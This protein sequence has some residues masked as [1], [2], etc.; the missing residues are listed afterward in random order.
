M[1]I[2]KSTG[3]YYYKISKNGKKTRISEKAYYKILSKKN[4]KY[5]FKGGGGRYCNFSD[6]RQ[7]DVSI[8]V[9]TPNQQGTTA[10]PMAAV[11]N[12]IDI[13]LGNN[14]MTCTRMPIGERNLTL[15]GKGTYGDIFSPGIV[16]HNTDIYSSDSLVTK[17][18]IEKRTNGNTRT[19]NNT[20]GQNK[21]ADRLG[22]DVTFCTYFFKSIEYELNRE[23]LLTI[24]F[25]DRP[26]KQHRIRTAT[27]TNHHYNGAKVITME[28]GDSINTIINTTNLDNRTR[29]RE[30]FTHLFRGCELLAHNRIML[31]D[32]KPDNM[33]L[34]R[35][36]P[37]Q[38]TIIKHIDL[39][40]DFLVT[41]L[42][43]YV[44]F[45]ENFEHINNYYFNNFPLNDCIRQAYRDYHTTAYRTRRLSIG[46]INFC[47][48]HPERE[49]VRTMLIPAGSFDDFLR[50]MV[51]KDRNGEQ[52]DA[53]ENRFFVNLLTLSYIG[54][55]SR[56]FMS[57]PGRG[58][59]NQY[60]SGYVGFLNFQ[61]LIAR[62][63]LDY[64]N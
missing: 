56:L 20:V 4:Y 3:G 39:G 33:L 40:L 48:T 46:I 10:Q 42:T 16:L 21:I 6:P 63:T 22:N 64:S 44:I 43:E 5:N 60:F 49:S 52:Y 34:K 45:W 2:L 38:A 37:G 30:G 15:L 14:R 7:L 50:E 61:D 1:E 24:N 23:T 35:T 53:A 54:Q 19:F 11:P 55:I 41:N 25:R 36:Q 12:Q 47:D 28:I 26:G 27:A 8:N 18:A 59:H 62:F 57:G 17:I 9:T 13:V 29:F 58:R 51:R 31:F 32:M